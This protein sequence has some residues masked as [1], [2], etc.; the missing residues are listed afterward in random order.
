MP[1]FSPFANALRIARRELRSGLRRFGVFLACL[2][3][4]VF[5][6]A[7]VGSFTAS[8][9]RGLLNDAAALLGGDVEIRLTHRPLKAEQ[10][11]YVE[12]L[13]AVSRTASLRTMAFAVSGDG[14]GLVELKAVD[15]AY[16]HYGEPGIEPEQSLQGALAKGVLVEES[17]LLRLR[18]AVGDELRLGSARF[19]IA[20][21]LHNEPDRVI[22]AFSLG[23]RVMI[24]FPGL[25]KTGLIQPGSL[26]NYRYRIKLPDEAD[27][28]AV[29]ASI[30]KD[31]VDSGWRVRTW[32]DAAP[33]I[34]RFLDRM[35]T[36]LTLLG[37]CALLVGGLGVSGAVRGYLDSKMVHIAA[38]KCLG[39][40]NRTIFISY[41]FQVLLLGGLAS[42]LGLA[43]AAVVPFFVESFV[44]K[45]LPIPFV[46]AIFPGVLGSAALFGLLISLL[47]SL[48]ALGNASR[49]SP[50]ILFRGYTGA[51]GGSTSPRI[52]LAIAV[53]AILLVGLTLLSSADT[54]MAAWFSV[55]A[56]ACF[57][58]FR[59]AT[60]LVIRLAAAIPL[61][62]EPR[63]ALGL[64]NIYRRGAPARSVMFSLGLGLTALVLISQVHVNLNALVDNEIPRDAPAFFL[65]DIQPDQVA[66][67]EE[68]VA[69]SPEIIKSRRFPTLRGRIVAIKGVPVDEAEISPDV[70]WAVRGDRF[71]SYTREMPEGTRLIAGEWWGQDRPIDSQLVSITA[72]LAKGFG[73]AIGDT[74]SVDVLGR[75]LT[76]RITSVREVDWSNMQLNFALL[77]SPGIL[78]SAPQTNIAA[79]HVSPADEAQVYTALTDRFANVSVIGVREVLENVSRTLGR[80]SA[81]F[82]AMAAL[83]LVV[84]LM[85]LAGALS[86]D[87]HRRIHDSVIFKVCGATRRDIILSFA[88]EFLILGLCAG[89]VAT[90]AGSLAAW[91]ILTRLMDSP[92]TLYPEVVLVTLVVAIIL[93]LCLGL[94]GTWKALGQ[95]PSVFLR[96]D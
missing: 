84:S 68:I 64:R 34:R 13:G 55:G 67:F 40:D 24:S 31:F 36:N 95:K 39:A 58:V 65:L 72:D 9:R 41:L 61:P 4:G 23:P 17:L 93:T 80:L 76:A 77:F 10:L 7:V 96:E 87:Q 48:K 90:F 49:V 3:L 53:T 62:R 29:K 45:S 74:I 57:L 6:I 60:A 26:V 27:A 78:S 69:Q 15:S 81:T 54:R 50:A 32:H 88:C 75:R 21:V 18:M 33:R 47:F 19:P 38:M 52:R 59:F 70:E 22:R 86:A 8:A 16:P 28:K 20:G 94:V 46:A 71:L 37:L 73:V 2:F 42:G 5:A 92:F 11:E 63:L 12:N 44:G 35:S 89:V 79:I 66:P 91:G 82:S 1:E 83:A 85:V 56:V 14:R 25:A 43:L 51:G 30:E